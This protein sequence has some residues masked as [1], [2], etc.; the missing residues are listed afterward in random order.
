MFKRETMSDIKIKNYDVLIVRILQLI[1]PFLVSYVSLLL[2]VL[3]VD[4]IA[5]EPLGYL[6]HLLLFDAKP[7]GLILGWGI[8][9]VTALV[10]FKGTSGSKVKECFLMRKW[11]L[12]KVWFLTL[13]RDFE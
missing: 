5:I 10:L 1:L 8:V 7:I 9:A 3:A 12:F 13:G 11:F 4:G 2:I 6:E